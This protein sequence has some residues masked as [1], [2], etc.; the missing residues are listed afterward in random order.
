MWP[1][2]VQRYSHTIPDHFVRALKKWPCKLTSAALRPIALS[3]LPGPIYPVAASLLTYSVPATR[4]I[5]VSFSLLSTV[6]KRLHFG[7]LHTTLLQWRESRAKTLEL[8]V[9]LRSIA[10]LGMHAPDTCCILA[11]RKQ[12][13]H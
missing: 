8:S 10:T 1:V 12:Q 11:L 7:N 6:N 2:Q 4:D 9:Q 3:Y 5:D 13:Y